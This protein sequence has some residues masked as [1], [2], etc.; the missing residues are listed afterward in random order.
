MKQ[1]HIF[2][3]SLLFS[4]NFFTYGQ[5]LTQTIKGRV[6]DNDTQIPLPGVSV[7]ITDSIPPAGTITNNDGYYIFHNIPLGRHNISFHY[8]GYKTQIFN[9][10]MVTSGKE[11]VLNAGLI[12]SPV[13]LGEV[14]VKANTR[15]DKPLNSMA[16]LSAR[17]LT[18]E[19]AS[20]YAGGVDDPHDL[21]LLLQGSPWQPAIT[22]LL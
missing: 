3:L 18:V 16:T 4:V 6:I 20:R 19:E 14:V 15:K 12:E 22:A 17:Q 8:L 5:H 13:E 7:V 10:V 9:E 21:L 2:I 1:L 11:V